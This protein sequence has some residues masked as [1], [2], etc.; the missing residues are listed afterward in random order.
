MATLTF[1]TANLMPEGP[2]IDVLIGLPGS[3]M[4]M[5]R[6]QGSPIPGPVAVKA[7]IDTGASSSVI[8]PSIIQQLGLQPI[9]MV[10]VNT[11]SCTVVI[12]L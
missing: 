4:D 2:V 12:P 1:N 8:Q 10:G 3:L 11:P 9:G 7:L 6:S 5:L